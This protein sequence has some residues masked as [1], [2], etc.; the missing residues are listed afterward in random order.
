MAFNRPVSVRQNRPGRLQVCTFFSSRG[1]HSNKYG[2]RQNTFVSAAVPMHGRDHSYLCADKPA[3]RKSCTRLSTGDTFHAPTSVE[4]LPERRSAWKTNTHKYS[5]L[6]KTVT[7]L[8]G[9]GGG[10]GGDAE[11]KTE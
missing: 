2:Y 3:H 8:R 9:G 6:S 1:V 10:G 4:Q 5:S 7:S 11:E